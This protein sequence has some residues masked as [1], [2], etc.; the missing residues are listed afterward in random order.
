MLD[1]I[2][3][4]VTNLSSLVTRAAF[5]RDG[6][7]LALER[8]GAI[9][10]Y[11]MMEGEEIFEQ[12][13]GVVEVAINPDGSQIAAIGSG[14][15]IYVWDI[16]T[17]E[18]WTLS[19]NAEIRLEIGRADTD[20]LHL[21]YSPDGEFLA[22]TSGSLVHVWDTA[23]AKLVSPALRAGP[24]ASIGAIA[25]SPD[26][27]ALLSAVS[28]G[29]VIRWELPVAPDGLV[30]ATAVGS[31]LATLSP[32]GTMAAFSYDD[33]GQVRLWD[34]TTDKPADGHLGSTQDR[35][36]DAAFSPDGEALALIS[37]PDG[38]RAWD[39]VTAEPVGP[40]LPGRNSGH[41]MFDSVGSALVLNYD[42]NSVGALNAYTGARVKI[43]SLPAT[44][45]SISPVSESNPGIAIASS[46][47]ET[48]V[49]DILTGD[50]IGGIE[51][52]LDPFDATAYAVTETGGL[53]A[54]ITQRTLVVWD[55]ASGSRILER[56][57]DELNER[58]SISFHGSMVEAMAFSSDA[59]Y[60]VT[61][62]RM[63][64]G[65]E[66]IIIVWDVEEGNVEKTLTVD[67]FDW[68]L[69]GFNL[70]PKDNKL[71]GFGRDGSLQIWSFP[72]LTPLWNQS[73]IHN[74]WFRILRFSN[75]GHQFVTVDEAGN[76]GLWDS[77][78]GAR[79]PQLWSV[80]LAEVVDLSFDI[81]GRRLASAG[82]DNTVAIWSTSTG[83]LE[84]G[85]HQLI[86]PIAMVA[87]DDTGN[88]LAIGG[89]DGSLAVWH[90]NT[91][92]VLEA[93]QLLDSSITAIKFHPT[94]PWLAVAGSDKMVH[95]FN[96]NN[97]TQRALFS[98]DELA[99]ELAW[100]EDGITLLNV[101][102]HMLVYFDTRDAELR[103]DISGIQNELDSVKIATLSPDTQMPVIFERESLVI[104]SVEDD[105]PYG[106]AI[107]LESDTL[108][109]AKMLSDGRILAIIQN[110]KTRETSIV[111]LTFVDWYTAICYTANR[112][113]TLSEREIYQLNT[114]P[115][116][117]KLACD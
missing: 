111:T 8:D 114:L 80:H 89:S 79:L 27:R 2:G 14:N 108:L 53:I 6:R 112:K 74:T 88:Q 31:S 78:T 13:A 11:S 65:L 4:R 94:E 69:Q 86:L 22:M 48:L 7:Y 107:Q 25:F 61:Q 109:D 10:I 57:W 60:L 64:S 62:S 100:T 49:V 71:I 104:W 34:M 55:V 96:I 9:I 43:P 106:P 115:E 33:L 63:I 54:G 90:L 59:K 40:L 84:I 67:E 99:N 91:D 117:V 98:V 26:S 42:N 37:H 81:N 45:D 19:S 28:D 16:H 72:E 58:F 39:L 51:E 70:G 46:I 20:A 93:H 85:P 50:A 52:G 103:S 66:W 105:H 3:L 1:Q 92:E 44:F 24:S 32:D 77:E 17:R 29:N 41:L 21:I 102:D 76:A 110:N 5:S 18:K 47:S 68:Q 116:N 75:D 97:W 113:F 30:L 36:I 56:S 83:E 87:F 82:A 95:I 101:G 12:A 73:G 23:T 38:I 15:N 35:V